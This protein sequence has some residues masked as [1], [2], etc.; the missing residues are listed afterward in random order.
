MRHDDDRALIGAQIILQPLHGVEVE[1][2]G[3][4]VQQQQVGLC[5]QQLAQLQPRAL[6]AGEG[7]NRLLILRGGKAQS[8][9][10]ALQA[11]APGVAVLFLKAV[12]QARV[13]LR[14][15]R[16]ALRV[17]LMDLAHARFHLPQ[18]FLHAEGVLKAGL[19]LL[20]DGQRRGQVVQLRVVA[21]AQ[22]ARHAQRAAVIVVLARE[23]FQQR[24]LARSVAPHQAHAVAVLHGEVDSLEHFVHAEGFGQLVG[25]HHDH[26][27]DS[28]PYDK[29]RGENQTG[30]KKQRS[31]FHFIISAPIPPRL[32]SGF[33][34]GRPQA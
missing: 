21:D 4:L 13:F 8:G 31:L 2:V 34:F 28:F 11:G 1:V 15:A 27:G 10:H 33:L 26:G 22:P 3:R 14:K 23:N 9:Q 18:L 16:K 24:G 19:H 17:A 12:G 25:L 6:A 20:P 7:G 29:A 5:Q 32:F 30:R